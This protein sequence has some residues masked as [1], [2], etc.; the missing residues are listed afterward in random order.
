MVAPYS[1]AMF[2]MVARSGMLSC[3]TPSPWNST[4]CPTTLA[5]AQHLGDVQHEVGRGHA[6]CQLAVDVDTD[7]VGHQE[8]DG[9]AQNRRPAPRSRRRPSPTV[10]S[11]EI[12]QVWELVATIVSG[13]HTP[14]LTSRPGARNSRLS[15]C[16]MPAPG[17]KR[18]MPVIGLHRPFD[19]LVALVVALDIELHIAQLRFREAVEID[20]QR[21]VE[22][23]VDRHRRLHVSTGRPSRAMLDRIAVRSPRS[24]MPAAQL[25]AMRPTVNGISSVRSALGLPVRRAP[26]TWSFGDAAAVAVAQQGFQ[27]DAEHDG[28]ARGIAD[29]PPRPA[30]QRVDRPSGRGRAGPFRHATRRIQWIGHLCLLTGQRPCVRR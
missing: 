14:S 5:F 23:H 3:A 8:A 1:G 12:M 9:L 29:T 19:E 10:P 17:G 27:H 30:R 28:Q 6:L 18:R 2:A 24:G 16:R 4:N 13:M 26:A 22:R 7:D 11:P 21:V 25:S 20:R 15:W